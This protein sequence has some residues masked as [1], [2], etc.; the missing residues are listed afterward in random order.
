M[1]TRTHRLLMDMGAISALETDGYTLCQIR[2]HGGQ[3]SQQELLTP[4]FAVIRLIRPT[5]EQPGLEPMPLE[6]GLLDGPLQKFS[7]QLRKIWLLQ[8]AHGKWMYAFIAQNIH[9]QKPFM[10]PRPLVLILIWMRK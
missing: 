10:L 8:P 7:L 9:L 4:D 3:L 2:K 6:A 1:R 5:V